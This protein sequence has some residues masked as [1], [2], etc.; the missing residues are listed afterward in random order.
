MAFNK[1]GVTRIA[2][3]IIHFIILTSQ[4]CILAPISAWAWVRLCHQWLLMFG[5]VTSCCT[6]FVMVVSLPMFCTFFTAILCSDLFHLFCMVL[7]PNCTS[8][9]GCFPTDLFCGGIQIGC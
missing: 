4:I 2:T 6:L 1:V 8:A 5:T 9:L 7:I 3:L